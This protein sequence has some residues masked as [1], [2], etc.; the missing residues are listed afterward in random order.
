M[1]HG[2]I[3]DLDGTLVDSLQGIAASVNHALVEA[4]HATHSLAAVQGFIG[5]GARILLERAAPGGADEALLLSLEETFKSHYDV[6]WPN[7]T[8]P[9]DGVTALLETL[10]RL[11]HPL[12]VLSNKPHPFTQTIVSQIFP[13][14]R[15]AEV[16]GQRA[17]IHH[18]PDPAGALEIA[19]SFGL[20]PADCIVIG[21]STM[22]IE[23]AKNA[24][25]KSIGVTWGFQDRAKL[26]AA[27][28]DV[29]ADNMDDL[30]RFCGGGFSSAV[31]QDNAE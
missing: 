17:G 29:L 24:G 12:A 16:L 2:L 21:D 27:G 7:G 6:S 22:D 4:G 11:G 8:L 9:Y 30:L 5:N 31:R 20:A 23:T 19:E 1:K 18:K 3:F 15:F 26:I 10:Q 13:G 25:M 14:I 28:A